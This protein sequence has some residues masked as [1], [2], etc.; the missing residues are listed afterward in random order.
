LH[1]CG[2]NGMDSR[3]AEYIEHVGLYACGRMCMTTDHNRICA[4]M[5]CWLWQ[6]SMTKL[7]MWCDH[8]PRAVQAGIGLCLCS[9]QHSAHAKGMYSLMIAAQ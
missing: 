4:K 3:I 5:T 6:T 2:W 1:T 8:V 9:A 7:M